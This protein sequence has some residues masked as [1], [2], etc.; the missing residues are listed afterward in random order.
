MPKSRA[1]MR[2]SRRVPSL[3]DSDI[4][5]EIDLVDRAARVIEPECLSASTADNSAALS[6][7]EQ[8]LIPQASRTRPAPS[9]TEEETTHSSDNA[10]AGA[11]PATEQHVSSPPVDGS[12]RTGI[13]QG[14][15]LARSASNSKRRSQSQHRSSREPETAVD[16]LYENQ[17]GCF[18]CGLP[19]FSSAAL[20]NLDPPAWTNFAH[21]P[22]PTSIRTAQVPDPSWVWVWP[23]WRVNRD[24]FI[25]TDKDGWEYSFA[26]SKK[27]SWHAPKWW[28]S[29][30]RRRAWIRRRVKK[31]DLDEAA[32]PYLINAGYFE[33]SPARKIH[34]SRSRSRTSSVPERM[35][36]GK[37]PSRRSQERGRTS[38]DVPSRGSRDVSRDT[39]ADADSILAKEEV[40]LRTVE[41]LML[42]LRRSRIDREKLEA[43]ENYIAHCSDDLAPLQDHMHDVMALFMFQTSR[44]L[45]LARLTHLYD[46]L[47]AA[48]TTATAVGSD[49]EGKGKEEE[50]GKEKSPE[51]HRR[52]V[53]NLAAAITHA[54]E[55]VRKLE[56]WSD[57]KAMAESGESGGAVAP[58]RGWGCAWEGIDNSGA[59]GPLKDTLP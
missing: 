49:G 33:V 10:L 48:A 16:V 39:G 59:K 1:H 45:L 27:F 29:F 14:N 17:R 28:N 57:I 34:H 44:K 20:G 19:L 25:D 8:P 41:D 15:N 32:D 35:S 12:K 18:C 53:E 24:D 5:H 42:V 3:V 52:R 43:V 46:E 31:V 9:A 47:T 2:S 58:D 22:S 51:R 4:D 11:R 21:K 30:V 23:E 55:E 13:A 36:I 40:Q 56:Y 50:E 7:S 54:D 26:F 37:S 6:H 38:K